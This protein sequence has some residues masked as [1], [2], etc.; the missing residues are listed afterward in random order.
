MSRLSPLAGLVS[1][2]VALFAV[3]SFSQSNSV[4]GTD[5]KLSTLGGVQVWGRVGA[6]PNGTSAMSMSTTA[7]NVGTVNVG[8]NAPMATNHPMISFLVCR[9]ENGRFSQVSDRSYVKHGFYATNQGGCATCTNPSG[10]PNTLFVGCSDTY[11]TGNNGDRYY[12]GPASEIDPWLG[13]WSSK[14]SL[15]DK[16]QPAV[17]PPFD[18]DGIRSLTN[19]MVGNMT[20]IEHRVNLTDADLDHPAATFYYQGMYTVRGEPESN[21]GNNTAVKRVIPTWTGS[22]WML[23]PNGSQLSGTILDQW[24]GATIDSNTN[25]VDDGRLFVGVKVTGPTAGQ[26]HYEYAVYN[27]DNARAVGAFHIPLGVGATVSNVGFRDIDT[28]TGNDWQVAQLSNELVFSTATDPQEWGTLY[29]FWFDS[30][31]GPLASSAS[32]NPFHAG[33]G[34]SVINVAT[35]APLDVC[36]PPVVYC[37]AKT[38]SLGCT[39]AIAISSAPSASAGSG[40]TL[41]VGN[42]LGKKSGLFFHSTNGAASTAFHGAFLCVQTPLVRHAIANSGGTNGA[43]DGV[44]T[45]DLNA[46]IASGADPALVAG[47]HVWLQHWSRDPADPF[48]D[49][50]SDAVTALICP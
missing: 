3:P 41:S 23:S 22:A 16:G 30:N 40:C 19:T 34:G 2:V 27:R 18:C 10:N 35:S 38:N 33:T 43:C 4:P 45:E 31:A 25:G 9:E 14:C 24:S 44:F 47:A 49:G 11:G 36:T 48:Q 6:F 12:L 42:A 26:W 46:Y 15:F 50:L 29:N 13:D 5:V 7:C 17:A 37:T 20:V 8:W 39:P 1:V 28:N 21:R 32:L